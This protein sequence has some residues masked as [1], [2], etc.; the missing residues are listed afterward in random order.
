MHCHGTLIHHVLR[1]PEC[2][3]GD[4]CAGPETI[5]HAFVIDCTVVGC[6]CAE[7]VAVAV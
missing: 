1:R 7:V 4:G 3:D 5:L 6:R 2:T